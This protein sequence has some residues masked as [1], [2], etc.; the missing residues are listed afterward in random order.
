MDKKTILEAARKN[1]DR[2]REWEWNVEEKSSLL[3]L[4]SVLVISLVLF[5]IDY[6]AKN[7]VSFWCTYCKQ[8]HLVVFWLICFV[9]VEPKTFWRIYCHQKGILSLMYVAINLQTSGYAVYFVLFNYV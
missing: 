9:K 5:A 7:I 3:T 1:G 8:M 4:I 6:F 2:G